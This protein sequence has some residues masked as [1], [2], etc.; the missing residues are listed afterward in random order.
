MFILS[1][2]IGCKEK[3]ISTE[4]ENNNIESDSLQSQSKPMVDN[5]TI[6][7]ESW[8]FDTLQVNKKVHIDDDV[9]KEGMQVNIMYI[10]PTN[11]PQGIDINRIQNSFSRLFSLEKEKSLS[12]QQAFDKINN[13]YTLGAKSE[14]TEWQ[15]GAIS[16]TSY[17]LSKSFSVES[18]YP[19]FI[20]TITSYY[21]YLGGAH[22]S[23]YISYNS[24]DLREGV[25]LTDSIIY[26]EGYKEKLAKLIQNEV[27]RRNESPDR[28]NH[29]MLLVELEEIEP[30]NNFYFVPEGIVYVY[31]QYEISPYVQGFVEITI[32]IEKIKILLKNEYQYI[33]NDIKS[34]N[35]K[36]FNAY[37]EQEE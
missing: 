12:P 11:S 2:L 7:L 31:N 35:I 13:E 37:R 16:F 20:T 29:I 4:K 30:N 22:G 28:D 3:N 17:E 8:Q 19:N 5:T 27:Q 33:V 15:E 34:N 9:D 14:A 32:P 10:Y 23:N 26:K 24:I 18:I 6:N 25:V 1:I 21:S 36:M